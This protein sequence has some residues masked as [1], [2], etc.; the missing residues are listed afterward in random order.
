MALGAQAKIIKQIYERTSTK[1]VVDQ[2]HA[3]LFK[4][5]ICRLGCP[6]IFEILNFNR[7]TPSN[8]AIGH[9]NNAC[10]IFLKN[11]N[12]QRSRKEVKVVK[13][14]YFPFILGHF[15][16]ITKVK[17]NL[18]SLI[19]SS[20][21]SGSECRETPKARKKSLKQ[22]GKLFENLSFFERCIYGH[23]RR[24][25]AHNF[26]SNCDKVVKQKR[27]CCLHSRQSKH[28]TT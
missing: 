17:N 25:G 10:K 26:T 23:I 19:F 14:S 15:A 8:G 21:L 20:S 22:F 3:L 11:I 6:L 2:R 28:G 16:K 27:G 24:F 4:I 13:N 9:K 5:G 18:F 7:L 1:H 12:I